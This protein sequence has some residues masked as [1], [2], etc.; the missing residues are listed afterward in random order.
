MD[1][2]NLPDG[3]TQATIDDL[4]GVRGVYRDG[5]WV[6]SKD[7]DPDGDVRLIQLAD[8]GDGEFRDKSARFLTSEKSAELNCTFLEHGDILVARMP[9]PLG[10]ACLFPLHGEKKFVTVVDVCVIRFGHNLVDERY[11]MY[12]LN[13][14]MSR[15]N[16]N[17]HQTGSTRK[18]ISRGNLSTVPFPIAPL[19]E[20]H[21]IVTKIEEMFSELDKGIENLMTA[22]EQLKVYRQALLK[23]AFEGKLTAQWR[24]ERT[25]IPAQAGIHSKE[26][27]DSRLR[28]NDDMGLESADALLKR[29]QHEREQRYQQQLQQWQTSGGSTPKA[30]KPLPPLTAEELAEL[31][32]LPGGWAWTR[33]GNT[34]VEVSDGP[35]GSNLKSSDYVDGG[36]R[37]IRLEN[38]GALE[39]I[40]G[41]ESFVTEEKYDLLKKHTVSAGDIIFSSFI[42]ENIRVALLPP[43]LTKAI[44]K[45]DCFCVRFSGE[46]L[47]NVFVVMFLSTRHVYKQLEALIHGV[48]R[49]RINTTQLKDV[50]I[51]VCGSAEQQVIIAEIE[52][53]LSEVDQLDQTLTTALQQAEALR[54]SILKKAFSGQLVA[55]DANDEPAAALLARIKAENMRHAEKSKKS[56]SK[57]K[58][59]E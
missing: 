42:T 46:T 39:F 7:Q 45:A 9:D 36:V 24:A 29:I 16:I 40:D 53:R 3:W 56:I 19:N 32:Q 27:L 17:D 34:N 38:I 28:G 50:V 6:E 25:V 30:P 59:N 55:Q 47:S 10:R 49:P 58:R 23:H 41:K 43:S 57:S 14:P 51:P 11:F 15:R 1:E 22:R 35:F 54:Q 5:D 20:Q 13:S 12:I 31:P 44:N 52:A 8:I 26:K 18:R 37:V 21:R 33:L 2:V 48:G 4:I